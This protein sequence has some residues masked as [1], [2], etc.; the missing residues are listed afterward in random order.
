MLSFLNNNF[1]V[2]FEEANR[3]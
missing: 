3:C 2:S 1:L